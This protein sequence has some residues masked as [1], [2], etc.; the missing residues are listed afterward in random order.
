MTKKSTKKTAS[1]KVDDVV[2]ETKKQDETPVVTE[3][4]TTQSVQSTPEEHKEADEKTANLADPLDEPK[5]LTYADAEKH[6]Q[7]G[8]L[9]KLP[10]WGGFWFN[11]I[12][13]GETFVY[14]KDGE[15]L[16]TPHEEYKER[17]DWQIVDPLD[18]SDDV[19]EKIT[20]YFLQLE[21]S[22]LTE[23]ENT[24]NIAEEEDDAELKPTVYNHL[25]EI[26]IGKKFR[27]ENEDK[28]YFV[29]ENERLSRYHD[30]GTLLETYP[31]YQLQDKLIEFID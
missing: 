15:I 17:N 8:Q 12:K 7:L 24:S 4:S 20:A 11:N 25:E 31:V 9:I 13:T 29:F 26:K 23:S 28:N 6:L 5:G 18:V 21:K 2:E 16:D 30:N 1:P 19:K 22:N 27:I 14:T 3:T 10:E